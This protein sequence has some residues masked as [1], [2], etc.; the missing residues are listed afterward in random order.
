MQK[1][2][3]HNVEHTV[4]NALVNKCIMRDVLNVSIVFWH[5]GKWVI[6]SRRLVQ[7]C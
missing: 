5:F 2:D 1:S 7:L 4:V 6:H 3:E